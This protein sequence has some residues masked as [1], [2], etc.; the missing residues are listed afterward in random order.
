MEEIELKKYHVKEGFPEGL[1]LREG[2]YN[3]K[4]SNHAMERFNERAG[5]DPI[6]PR[7]VNIQKDKNVLEMYTQDGKIV[8]QLLVRIQYKWNTRMF[9]I[10]VPQ[11]EVGFVKTIWFTEKNKTNDKGDNG[12]VVSL[13]I[14]NV[15]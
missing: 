4:Y 6:Y 5:N 11:G 2:F 13:A 10:V 1:E 9:L 14:S 8:N 12:R 3:L 15:A 7:V